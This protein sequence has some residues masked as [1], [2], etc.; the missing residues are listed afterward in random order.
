MFYFH[1]YLGK[2]FNLTS[3]FFKWVETTYRLNSGVITP[4][5]LILCEYIN[6]NIMDSSDGFLRF[7]IENGGSPFP[8]SHT[9]H[10]RWFKQRDLLTSPKIWVGCMSPWISGHVFTQH[11]KKATSR[12]AR[13]AK[14]V[15]YFFSG[16]WFQIFSLCSPLLGEDSHSD[17]YF[18]KGLKP[19]PSLPIWEFLVIT[20]PYIRLVN[21]VEPGSL[22]RWDCP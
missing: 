19:P 18:S 22:N 6:E 1:P 17:K 3:I 10:T 9:N 14:D 5:I 4:F 12:I 21:G 16:W 2:W 8:Y 13:Y 11:P 7:P 20:T 15:S